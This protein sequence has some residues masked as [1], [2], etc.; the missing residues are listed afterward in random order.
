M[1]VTFLQKNAGAAQAGKPAL[2]RR[3]SFLQKKR[4]SCQDDLHRF[5]QIILHPLFP[6]IPGPFPAAR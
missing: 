5:F 2:R 1:K 3:V 4:I 6:E